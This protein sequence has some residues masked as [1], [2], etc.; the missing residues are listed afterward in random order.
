MLKT[1]FFA[2]CIFS[3]AATSCKKK[4]VDDV[5]VNFIFKFDSIQERLNNL[6]VP[7]G[8]AAGNKAQSPVFNGMSA[9]YLELIWVFVV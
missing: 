6:G 2:I 3:I 1:I 5:Q 7:A 8:V 4:T 9:Y